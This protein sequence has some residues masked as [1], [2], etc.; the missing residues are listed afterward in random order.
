M[1]LWNKQFFIHNLVEICIIS[2]RANFLRTCWHPTALLAYMTREVVQVI[3]AKLECDLL[4]TTYV[5]DEFDES[6]ILQSAVGKAVV[7]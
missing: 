2:L 1:K 4:K 6:T 7:L 5:L 3:V